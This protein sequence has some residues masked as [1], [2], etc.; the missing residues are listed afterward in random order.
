M[1][2]WRQCCGSKPKCPCGVNFGGICPC[3]VNFMSVWRQSVEV[4]GGRAKCPCGVNFGGV[5]PCGVNFMSVWRQFRGR[6][7]REGK[8]S[9]WRQLRWIAPV[10]RQLSENVRVGSNQA[11][12]VRV[13]SI[14]VGCGHTDACP[15]PDACKQTRKNAWVPPVGASLAVDRVSLIGVAGRATG[16]PTYSTVHTVLGANCHLSAAVVDTV[17]VGQPLLEHGTAF[18][19]RDSAANPMCRGTR[20]VQCS[21]RARLT[22]YWIQ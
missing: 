20:S 4:C 12:F 13:G 10:W 11:I 15:C 19:C 8:M 7:R 21:E 14:T 17:R 2:V 16:S 18:G 6:P 9:V 3:G 1:S 22:S 5:C